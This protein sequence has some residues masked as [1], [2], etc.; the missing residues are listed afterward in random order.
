MRSASALLGRRI[1]IAGSVSKDAGVA[2][3][4]EVGCARAFLAALVG[5]L[6]TRGASFVIPVDAE[7]LRASDGLPI[8]FDWMVWE[9]VY[10]TRDHR[11]EGARD[12]VAIA[13]QHHKTELQIP[14][15]F[16]EMWDTLRTSDAVQIENVPHW[17]MGSK[18]MEAQARRGDMLI[19]LGGNDG[20]LFLADLYHDAGKPVVPLNFTLC[21]PTNGS[22]KLF[23]LGLSR[24][25]AS[26]LFRASGRNSHAWM[27]RINH[28]HRTPVCK[29]VDDV[30]ELLEAIERPKAFGIRLLNKTHDEFDAVETF[31]QEV[32]K[33]FVEDEL[34]HDLVLIDGKQPYEHA[35]VDEDIFQK[36]HRS[37]FV[38]A[39]L[40][41]SRAN[42][43]LELGYALGRSLQTM[44]TAKVGTKHPFDITTLAAHHWETGG[45]QD[46]R[47][48]A[49]REHWKS[50]EKRPPLVSESPLIP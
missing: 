4:E 44:V 47:I 37:S 43:F 39:D 36:L 21:P 49:L 34:G 5:S 8:T 22:L 7:K 19:T 20:V 32:V 23:N 16:A 6:I 25:V 10:N 50:I 27:N 48:T 31:Y 41:G 29:R 30:L 12:P 1:H 15:Q 42:C 11:P 24:S 17:N 26:R 38:I 13:V 2:T 35:R 28:T 40:T 9:A 14:G 3:A 45:T 33:P 46:A 18:R